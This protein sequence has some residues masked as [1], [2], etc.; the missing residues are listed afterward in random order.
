MAT[1]AEIRALAEVHDLYVIRC[2][3][4]GTL[5]GFIVGEHQ[6]SALC[7]NCALTEVQK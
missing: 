5:V 2:D 6:E 7:V 3:D 4:C 1:N